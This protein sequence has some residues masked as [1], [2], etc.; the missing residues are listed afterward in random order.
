VEYDVPVRRFSV[1][2][3]L[4]AACAI[5]A[6]PTPGAD[7]GIGIADA[8]ASDSGPV[9]HSDAATDAS[10]PSI[11]AGA[12]E[13]AFAFPANPERD[14]AL[15]D[16]FEAAPASRAACYERGA[17]GA[18]DCETAD[19]RG[20]AS[21][22]VNRGDCCA[23]RTSNL[24]SALSFDCDDLDVCFD[25]VFAQP[26]GSP[27]PFPVRS[28][29]LAAGGDTS[30]DS[31]VLVGEAIDLASER[32]V[33]DARFERT[34]CGEGVCVASFAVG[35]TTQSALG[36]SEHVAPLVAMQVS[37]ARE[38]V[39]LLAAGR[40][41]AR[42]DF[43]PEARWSL[44]VRPDG[45]ADLLR[46]GAVV[47]STRIAPARA[48]VVLYG[49]A[50]NP[51]ATANPE[52]P[53]VILTSFGAQV[54]T[55][56]MVRAWDDASEVLVFDGATPG[57]FELVTDVAVART[58]DTRWLAFTDATSG[59]EQL[60]VA[61]DRSGFELDRNALPDSYA[62][63]RHPTLAFDG[64][65]LFLVSER[66][67]E[68]SSSLSSL[69]LDD[70]LGAFV[71]DTALALNELPIGLTDVSLAFHRGHALLVG[72]NV[73]S[74]D[75]FVRG[76]D[77]GSVWRRVSSIPD[78]ALL[79]GGLSASR[80]VHHDAYLLHH[81]W[82]RGARGGLGL[83]ASDELVAWRPVEDDQLSPSAIDV[84]GA[85]A[86]S[87]LSEGGTI[88]LFY[89]ADDGVRRRLAARTRLAPAGGTFAGGA[90]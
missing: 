40:V 60:Y 57:T 43:V 15:A 62:D 12:P 58:A 48:R 33:L 72:R 65:D 88:E 27:A 7:A 21:C 31:G 78:A 20:L 89:V 52:E 14:T 38:G 55:C 10:D 46:D 85:R 84:L 73:A 5:E 23:P 69:R 36:D 53:Q 42:V 90:R 68:L 79:G 54:A 37:A 1:G 67:T 49:H 81:A 76:P 11:D 74:L 16:A 2:F 80:V 63:A 18:S 70:T 39:A 86:S 19:C 17:D 41:V 26:F 45:R 87:A 61:R 25:E 30:F 35:L 34:A 64:T 8:A 56:D 59:V 66:P 51:S 82:R 77:T 6:A 28:T 71:E 24:P 75:A 29:G 44:A 13:D 50:T 47:A 32:V 4:F 3:L 83:V 9:R 22:C